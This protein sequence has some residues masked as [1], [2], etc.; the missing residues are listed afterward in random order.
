MATIWILTPRLEFSYF[1][2]DQEEYIDSA[3]NP[4]VIPSAMFE[5]SRVSF[6]PELSRNYDLGD[7]ATLTPR[8]GF[9]STFDSTERETNGAITAEDLRTGKIDVG[10]NYRS[11]YGLSWNLGGYY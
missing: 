1:R 5:L 11:I 7:D 10:V 3:T 8:L 9:T 2:E 4:T 6:G